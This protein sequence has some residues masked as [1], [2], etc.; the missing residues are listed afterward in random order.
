MIGSQGTNK[1]TLI[2][3]RMFILSVA[4]VVV[5]GGILTRLFSLQVFENRKYTTLSER[6]R[7]REWKLVPQRGIIEDFFGNKIADNTQV[8]QLL[9]VPENVFRLD[10]VF[11]RLKNIINLKDKKI[12]KIKK[13]ISQQKAWE[14]VIIS[15]N[16]SWNEFSK[17]NLFLHEIPG[18]E[19]V[20]AVAR[21]YPESD[22]F[23]HVIGYVGP[24]SKEDLIE[25]KFLA[26]SY[27][28]GTKI[29]KTG[30]EKMLDKDL[31]GEP[32][33]HRY[34]VNAYG[35]KIKEIKFYKGLSGQNF[36]TTLDSVIQR[37][38]SELLVGKSGSVCIMDVFSGDI[39]A[40]VSS[41]SFNPNKFVHGI[42]HKD[43]NDLLKNENK[44]LVNKSISGLYPPGSTVKPVLA[45]SALES[46]V[47][48]PKLVIQCEGKVEYHGQTYHCWKK[49]GHGFVDLRNAIK[50]SCDTYFYEVARRLGVDRLSVTAK[51]FGLGS[52]LLEN[53]SESRRGVVPS[54]KW[55]LK[56]LGK[57]WYLGE[58]LITGIGQ[59]YFLSTPLELCLM[60]AQFANGGYKIKP[61][62]IEDGSKINIAINEW[63]SSLES[64]PN[65]W[66]LQDFREFGSNFM[67]P[68]FR[69]KENIKFIND[70]LYGATNEVMGTSYRS[71]H[72]KEKYIYAGKTGTSQVK[73]VTEEQRELEIKN[74]DLPY[75]ERDHGLFVGFAPYKNPQYALS[76][77]IEHG[78]SGSSSAAPIVKKL[79]KEL[80]NRDEL[81]KQQINKVGQE[82]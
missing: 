28:P 79:V 55:K 21:H 32:G 30:A 7:L 46:H 59:G 17:L 71:R 58:T 72:T 60:I 33:Y 20:V 80:V 42:S 69:N 9:M 11:F 19:L 38:A 73:K 81:R 70:A 2:N 82:V 13:K 34:E 18:V 23:S 44:P 57:N 51:K 31:I 10:T 65:E 54:T 36:R 12:L 68:L 45:L 15:N 56:N 49:K 66:G 62:I 26:S 25:K 8:Y 41:P 77:I 29:G 78:G 39:I 50:Q 75:K 24:A 52:N 43:W 27:T 1:N 14:P 47:I 16:L 37:K 3:R 35:K 40:M 64:N 61:R 6:N 74:E 4:K 63:K 76:V 48:S 67:S 53:Y 22:V 5:F